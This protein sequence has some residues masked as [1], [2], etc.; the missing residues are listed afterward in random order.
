MRRILV[1]YIFL[2]T[3]NFAY[4]ETYIVS[5]SAQRP[6]TARFTER[7]RTITASGSRAARSISHTFRPLRQQ[8]RND[9]SSFPWQRYYLLRTS[10]ALPD[11][12]L[13]QLSSDP[14]IT[15][16][17]PVRRYSVYS[18]PNDSA[19]T[20]QWNL[21]RIGVRYLYQEGTIGPSL[22]SVK[23]AII[24]TGIDD[25]HPDLSAAIAVNSG[26]YGGGKESNGI[27]DDLNGFVDDWKGYDFVQFE[28]ED[29]GDW[30][31]RDNDPNDEHGH[32]TAVAGII[33]A[34]AGNAIGIAGIAP[35]Q[36][37]PLRAFGKNGTGN[38]ID[39]AAAIVYAAENGADVINMSFGDVVRSTLMTDAIRFAYGRGVVLVASSG[40]DGS[41][42]PH[43]P[44]DIAGVISVGSVGRTDVRSFF[45]SYSPSLD[46]TAPGEQ[47]ATTVPGGGYSDQFSGTSAA[48][49]HVSG[50]AALIIAL[51][52]KKKIS[53]PAYVRFSNE[54]IRG[55]LLQSADD[56]GSYGWDAQTGAGRLNAV[57]AVRSL[58]GASVEIHTPQTDQV[59]GTDSIPV[60]ITALGPYITSVTLS[61]G[62]GTDPSM[63]N[64]LYARFSTFFDRDTVIY[65]HPSSLSAGPHLLRLT[66]RNASGVDTEFRQRF[67]V[68]PPPPRILSFRYR[69]SVII[70]GRYGMLI[71]ARVDRNM[72]G[73]LYV[74][75]GPTA[76][77]TAIRSQGIQ[78]NH[79]FTVTSDDIPSLVQ[80]EFY[81][82]FREEGPQGRSVR[83][84]TTVL[85]GTDHFPVRVNDRPIRTT[86]FE[87]MPFTLP[88]AY[89]SGT[90]Q[91]IAGM[92][93]IILNQYDAEGEFG[94]LKAFQFT[95][96]TFEQRDSVRRSWIPRA[97]ER[98]PSSGGHYVLVQE[99]GVSRLFKVDTTSQ[100]YFHQAVWGDSSDVWACAFTDLNKDG[101]N[102]II[103]RSSTEFLIYQRRNDG[104][105]GI[106]SR[107]PNPTPPLAGE[108]RNQ[109][110]PPRALVGSFTG[111][112][113]TEIVVA[114]YDGDL[115]LYRQTAPGAVTFS[116]AAVD[117]TE[118]YGMSE[119]LAAGDLD[120]DGTPEIIA[121]GH[122]N[123]DWNGDREYDAP[124]W[125]VRVFSHPASAPAGTLTLLW[126][127]SFLGVKA[128][129]GYDNGI[130]AGRFRSTDTK[131]ALF[132]SLNPSLYVFQ[133]NSGSRTMES[134]WHHPSLSNTV[135][136][137][138]LNGDGR[139]EIGFRT[140][141]ATEFWSIESGTT[142]LTP[143]G[144]TARTLSAHSVRIAWQSTSAS[145]SVYRGTDRNS[146]VFLKTV[147]GGNSYVDTTVTSG[148]RYYYAV[149]ASG[150]GVSGLSA[151]VTAVPHTAPVI[152]EIQQSGL[153][154][155]LVTLSSAIAEHDVPS[156]R[157]LLDPMIPSSGVNRTAPQ[158]LLV[159]FPVAIP[160]GPRTVRI[161]ALKDEDGM[162]ADT[163]VQYPFTASVTEEQLFIVRSA[164]IQN[165]RALV[166]DFNRP[167]NGATA[168]S[169]GSYNVRTIV[170][171][172]PI[173]SVD[174]VAPATVRLNLDEDIG[175]IAT[176]IEVLV[177]ADVAAADGTKLNAG[178]GQTLSI[179]QETSSLKDIVVY[180]NPARTQ[181]GV[182]FINIP[183]NCA[184]SIFAATGERVAT[185]GGRTG[186]EGT[187][188]DLRTESGILVSTGIYLYRI[189][190][191]NDAGITVG[192]TM[193][194]FAVIR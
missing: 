94:P 70:R 77:Y 67:I 82:E 20:A 57:R 47:I 165:G 120:G 111:S 11:S 166:L 59:L 125:T 117:T 45:A 188:W 52:K 90:F 18:I 88:S 68:A 65:L 143:F 96:A 34:T 51:E 4:A 170:R 121:A 104:S 49:P 167:V 100:S 33:G 145:H 124:V 189:E 153:R 144:V 127:Q 60:V 40:N 15:S 103:A 136:V 75:S 3:L 132:L 99:H 72:T 177:N 135:L 131:D 53:D 159:T 86:G 76:P 151:T 12:M 80:H 137:S 102:E 83:F 160:L 147:T 62:T 91:S 87:R 173:R 129:S 175:K 119:F 156:T 183:V 28:S 36:L 63:W 176:R 6:D 182:S 81:C 61:V 192:T 105:Y 95:G 157:F 27:D 31:E 140:S 130:A 24:D 193:G 32:G 148:T 185:L 41:A 194:K 13:R 46:L 71:E 58:A 30:N 138:D 39:I 164:S 112:G 16:V 1:G 37:L 146:L 126:Q 108:A 79:Y 114:D 115:I 98:E 44:S 101:I 107:L 93:T 85:A 97:L 139:S 110:G 150:P 21:E 8:G 113:A 174:S 171:S 54:D 23:V 69:D 92:P 5:F 22:P 172:F 116:V 29:I 128:G 184:V 25:D 84:P 89:L 122:A 134:I 9:A 152:T 19:F 190:Q 162:E 66:V 141:D 74:R 181:T 109:F 178:K 14:S 169:A 142:A 7:F 186:T 179:A 2:L 38:D 118:L 163:T 64:E 17:E 149:S 42:A 43:Y 106:V 187:R 191:F 78:L 56:V 161:A 168:F 154:Q 73:T 35:A 50:V 155:L 133:W 26:E 158:R 180:P 123:P 55:M 10:S 48:A